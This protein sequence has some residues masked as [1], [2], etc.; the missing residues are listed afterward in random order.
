[1]HQAQTARSRSGLDPFRGRL[2]TKIDMVAR[3]LDVCSFHAE[4]TMF[5][6][7]TDSSKSCPPALLRLIQRPA[8]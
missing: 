6:K 2:N 7:P 5:H 3:N 1:M 8:A 4:K